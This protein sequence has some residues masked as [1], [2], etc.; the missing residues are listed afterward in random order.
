MAKTLTAH[1][2]AHELLAGPDLPVHFG[3]DYGDHW[4]TTVAPTVTEF[5]ESRVKHSDYHNMP[6]VLDEDD[7]RDDE[8]YNAADAVILLR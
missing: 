2:L 8:V 5:E 1:E 3:Y 4:H 7:E 6:K